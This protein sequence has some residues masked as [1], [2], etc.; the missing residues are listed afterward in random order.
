MKRAIG[1]VVCLVGLITILLAS[2]SGAIDSP[3][4]VVDLRAGVEPLA[5]QFDSEKGRHR[6]LVLLS[7]A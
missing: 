7:P 4:G 3:P 2:A 6:L 1:L 5:E